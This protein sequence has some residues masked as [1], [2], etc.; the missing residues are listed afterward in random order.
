MGGFHRQTPSEIKRGDEA[1]VYPNQNGVYVIS[2]IADGAEI[3][4]YVGKGDI[5]D[6]RD[7]HMS[8][9]EKNPQLKE[10]TQKRTSN[11][12][13]YYALT[14]N[15]TDMDNAEYTLFTHYGGLKKLYNEITPSGKLDD[16]VTWPF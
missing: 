6:N 5:K 1:V 4:R 7:R 16:T 15:D 2:E 9:N 14:E 11:Y 12:Q 3:A 8:N 10:L 13:F